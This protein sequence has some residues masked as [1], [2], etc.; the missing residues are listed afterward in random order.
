M[1]E[2]SPFDHGQCG[3]VQEAAVEGRAVGEVLALKSRFEYAG[4]R[5]ASKLP[6]GR[7]VAG[8]EAG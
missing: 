6:A 4:T 1:S 3:R 7:A 8:P 2:P 5:A